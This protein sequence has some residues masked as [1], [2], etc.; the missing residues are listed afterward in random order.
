MARLDL[1][2]KAFLCC[3]FE[4]KH[5]R[6]YPTQILHLSHLEHFPLQSWILLLGLFSI[7]SLKKKLKQNSLPGFFIYQAPK[8]SMARLDLTFRVFPSSKF[9]EKKEKKKKNIPR[10]FIYHT[11]ISMAKLVLTFRAFLSS[12]Y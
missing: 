2:F 5:E 9:E 10:F 8:F 1:T 12:K 6:K 11:N 4:E 3:I 7:A